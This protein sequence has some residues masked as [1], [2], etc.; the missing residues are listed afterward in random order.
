MYHFLANL[1]AHNKKMTEKSVLL[2]EALSPEMTSQSFP[3]PVFG[4]TVLYPNGFLVHQNT[5]KENR[6]GIF[7]AIIV[8]TL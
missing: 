8:S 6:H 3:V 1:L 4:L 7:F 5:G 2:R